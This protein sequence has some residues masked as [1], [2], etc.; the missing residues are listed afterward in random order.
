MPLQLFLPSWWYYV[1]C[2][3]LADDMALVGSKGGRGR[4][5]RGGGGGEWT[6]NQGD[7]LP[8]LFFPP[9]LFA[10]KETFFVFPV[11]RSGDELMDPDPR[12]DEGLMPSIY[13]VAVMRGDGG[14][15]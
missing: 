8:F 11:R 13:R 12:L 5:G 3:A 9:S 7:L 4:E 1:W 2:G 14:R 10:K 6:G 15:C